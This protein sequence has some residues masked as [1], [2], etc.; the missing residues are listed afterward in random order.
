M[1]GLDIYLVWGSNGKNTGNLFMTWSRNM[2][3]KFMRLVYVVPS[4]ILEVP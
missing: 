1:I 2:I 3:E 4:R